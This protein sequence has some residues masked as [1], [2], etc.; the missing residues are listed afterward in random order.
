MFGTMPVDLRSG[1]DGFA[2][3]PFACVSGYWHKKVVR[4]SGPSGGKGAK[5]GRSPSMHKGIP[6]AIA[7][8]LHNALNQIG[9]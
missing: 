6:T 4:S 5:E 9:C 2:L 1:R 7:E 8:G 3:V